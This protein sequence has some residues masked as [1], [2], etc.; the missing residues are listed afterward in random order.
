VN[1]PESDW[2]ASDDP[3]VEAQAV[4]DSDGTQ[5]ELAALDDEIVE[6][7][8]MLVGNFS[9]V[10]GSGARGRLA[11]V[12]FN[13]FVLLY[14]PCMVTVAATRQEF[15]TRWMLYQIVYTAG[16]AWLAAVLVFQGG[17]LLGLG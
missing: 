14:V 12:A 8:P 4:A 5:G 11:A 15:G 1:V 2:L 17:L 16:L 10:A 13:V 9:E 7:Q 3:V 6:L